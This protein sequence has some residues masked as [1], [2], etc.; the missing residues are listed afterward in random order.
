M[1]CLIS[2]LL[3]WDRGRKIHV[4]LYRCTEIFFHSILKVIIGHKY[5][6]LAEGEFHCVQFWFLLATAK[7]YIKN[8][9]TISSLI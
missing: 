3:A 2:V 7:G 6:D 1:H 5:V 4:C 8:L 9:E